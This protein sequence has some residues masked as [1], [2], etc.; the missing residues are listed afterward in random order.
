M[1]RSLSC[2]A[3]VELR[4]RAALQACANTFEAFDERRPSARTPGMRRHPS[5]PALQEAEDEPGHWSALGWSCESSRDCSPM[6]RT[7][8]RDA[9]GGERASPTAWAGG[10]L[11]PSQSQSRQSST[12]GC[13]PLS[14]SPKPSPPSSRETTPRSSREESALSIAVMLGLDGPAS[15]SLPGPSDAGLTSVLVGIA[16]AKPMPSLPHVTSASSLDSHASTAS[17]GSATSSAESDARRKRAKL[18]RGSPDA[19]QSEASDSPGA[20]DARRPHLLV[21]GAAGVG[22][23]SVMERLHAL[24]AASGVVLRAQEG[25]AGAIPSKGRPAVA[26]VVWDAGIPGG[27]PDYVDEHVRGLAPSTVLLVFVNKTD[28]HP[29]PLPETNA[30]KRARPNTLA[31][32]G[33]AQRGTN[34]KELW[35]RIEVTCAPRPKGH[36]PGRRPSRESREREGRESRESPS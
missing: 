19:A 25:R 3:L 1:E 28:V 33:S 8:S 17:A 16:N 4:S 2:P 29:C 21:L 18:T 26:L 23:T 10:S 6:V 20:A 34:M 27:L 32:S 11:P 36:S 35:R 22:K 5:M 15:A 7:G 12:P 9:M 31:I 24:A 14:A 13:S 30:L